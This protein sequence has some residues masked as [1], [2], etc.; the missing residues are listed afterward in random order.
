MGF[1]WDPPPADARAADIVT[2]T[3]NP[4]LDATTDVPELVAGPKLRCGAVRREAGGGGVNVA[5]AVTGLGGRAL[6]VLAA[7]GSTGAEIERCLVDEGVPRRVIPIAGTSR[8]NVAVHERASGG[9]Y[10]LV[11]PG[12][13]LTA[14]EWRRCIDVAADAAEGDLLV[15][16]GSLP[17]GVPADAYARL[18]RTVASRGV[19]LLLDTAG[20]GLR[21]GLGAGVHLIKPNARELDELA[22]R[23]LDDAGREEFAAS[24]VR[25]GGADVVIVTLGADGALVVDGGGPTRIHPP[26]VAHPDSA[27]GAG[28]N[29]MAG[30]VLALAAARDTAGACAVGV[31]AAAAALLTPGTAPCRRADLEAMLTAM[32]RADDVAVLPRRATRAAAT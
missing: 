8:E 13:A 21:G 28:D 2:L 3:L 7:G 16:S 15:A 30:L 12:P 29:F 32:G 17:P 11:M 27:V 19:R 10:R 31:A 23:A 22:G 14:A 9:L 25:G 26:P 6:A 4:A 24:I 20:P 5:R 18:A 1:P